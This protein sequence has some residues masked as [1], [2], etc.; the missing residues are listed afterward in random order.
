M[1]ALTY[2][3]Q[4]LEELCVSSPMSKMLPAPGWAAPFRLPPPQAPRALTSALRAGLPQPKLGRR[5][6][7]QG[8]P[9]KAIPRP[10]EGSF[11][12]GGAGNQTAEKSALRWCKVVEGLLLRRWHR[13]Q[14]KRGH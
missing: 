6:Q 11:S 8:F 1:R 12:P 4:G 13:V 5:Q 10:D 2:L 9:R 7:A 3:R 14:E